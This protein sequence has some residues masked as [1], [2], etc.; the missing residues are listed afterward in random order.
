M[1]NSIY[2]GKK[3]GVEVSVHNWAV[4][5]EKNHSPFLIP[6]SQ[7]VLKQVNARTREIV[8]K[9]SAK[10]VCYTQHKEHIKWYRTGW[11]ANVIRIVLFIIAIVMNY[12]APGSGT[13]FY[14]WASS[15]TAAQIT[16]MVIITLLKA[17]L[18][19]LI[20]KAIM[21]HVLVPLF[22]AKL[23]LIFTIA[24]MMYGMLGTTGYDLPFA[25]NVSTLSGQQ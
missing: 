2:A 10:L 15:L 13:S 6:L 8:L 11:F 18:I 17:V 4:D 3:D 22:G 23:A 5:D 19:G 16:S 14:A 21:V 7:T 9:Y 24:A 25:T 12:Y 20:V 1:F